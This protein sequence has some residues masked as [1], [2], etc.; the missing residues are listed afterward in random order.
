MRHDTGIVT[1]APDVTL[2]HKEYRRS[3]IYIRDI[4]ENTFYKPIH[5]G[6][7]REHIYKP[8]PLY[9]VLYA[10]C[11]MSHICIIYICLMSHICIIYI[12]VPCPLYVGTY[13][14]NTG[15][16]QPLP[17]P[18]NTQ[19][20][21][22]HILENTFYKPIHYQPLPGPSNTQWKTRTTL[23]TAPSTEEARPPGHIK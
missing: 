15:H 20:I 9:H 17:G 18:S 23:A 12:Y 3:P 13:T 5:K 16:H 8:G 22:E 1:R 6:H 10:F 14:C 21:R 11:P 4:L 2:S 7:I 19:W